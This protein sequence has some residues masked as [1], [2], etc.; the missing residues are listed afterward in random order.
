[1][2]SENTSVKRF[3]EKL[4]QL[5]LSK[6]LTLQELS[7]LLGYST[8]SYLNEIELGRKLPSLSLII[9]I[10]RTFNISTDLLLFDELDFETLNP[11][12]NGLNDCFNS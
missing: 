2:N 7:T 3:G 10:A 12:R 9:R 1:M 6:Q 5:R 8:H 11:T 4:R